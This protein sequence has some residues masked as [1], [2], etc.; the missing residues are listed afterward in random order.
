[1]TQAKS[2]IQATKNA[3][4]SSL[5]QWEAAYLPKK[6]E[7]ECT[8]GDDSSPYNLGYEK[9]KKDMQESTVELNI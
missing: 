7:D 5:Y 1:M 3:S 8:K 4:F 6:F 2:V 9:G